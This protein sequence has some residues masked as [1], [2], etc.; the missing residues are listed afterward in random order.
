MVEFRP[1]VRVFD[2]RSHDDG[3]ARCAPG[4]TSTAGPMHGD[5]T[6]VGAA[7]PRVLAL[8]TV[9]KWLRLLAA[10]ACSRQGEFLAKRDP[11]SVGLAPLVVYV[12]SERGR[13]REDPVGGRTGT[14]APVTQVGL[15]NINILRSIDTYLHNTYEEISHF[16][17]SKVPSDLKLNIKIDLATR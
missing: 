12:H 3:H 8:G 5:S 4:V 1:R 6:H 17:S 9:R 10:T 15:T 13:S 11:F 16:C 14:R 2:N 7:R